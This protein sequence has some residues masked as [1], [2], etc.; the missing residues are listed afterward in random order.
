[1]HVLIQ[2]DGDKFRIY[3]D[4]KKVAETDFQETLG[5]NVT[6]HLGGEGGETFAGAMDDVAIF[7]RALD[8]DEIALIMEGVET[9]LPVEPKGKLATQWA[10]LKR[11][12]L[13]QNR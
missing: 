9:F 6:Y 4:G 13:T 2:G 12:G 10:D 11:S 5:N 3:A 8:E 7:T 1:M